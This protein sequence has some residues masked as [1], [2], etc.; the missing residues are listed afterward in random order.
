MAGYRW[1]AYRPRA[2][3]RHD[4]MN[5]QPRRDAGGRDQ[6]GK[7]PPRQRQRGEVTHVRSGRQLEE[8]RRQ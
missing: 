7:A 6:T 5:H 4:R 2:R 8:K 1:I 3:R